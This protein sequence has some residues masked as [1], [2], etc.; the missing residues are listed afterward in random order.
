MGQATKWGGM[1][2]LSDPDEHDDGGVP[3]LRVFLGLLALVLALGAVVLVTRDVEPA[4]PPPPAQS[5]SP[6]FALTD[7]EAIARFKE[8]HALLLTAYRQRDMSL[9][10]SFLTENSP[11][12]T[13]AVQEIRQLLRDRV[14]DRA[15]IESLVLRVLFNESDLITVRHKWIEYPRFVA[16]SGQNV[17]SFEQPILQVVDWSLRPDHSVWKIFDSDVIRTRRYRGRDV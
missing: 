9:L 14:F 11:L 1:R 5:A 16:E 8:L 7:E 6:N 3:P 13:R 10:D 17:T 15:K 12:R 4:P 2:R